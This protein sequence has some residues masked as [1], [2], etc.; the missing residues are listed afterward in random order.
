MELDQITETIIGCAFRVHTELGPGLFENIY[1]LCLQHELRKAG[2]NVRRQV[3]LPVH[4]DGLVFDAA[5][6]LDLLVEEQ[7]VIELKAVEQVLDVHKAQLISHLKLGGYRVGLLINFNV[8]HLR[9]GIR[10]FIN[11]PKASASSASSL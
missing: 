9:H 7:V 6:K 8:T 1:E 3:E 11:K 2:L 10:R 4:Y 5:Y